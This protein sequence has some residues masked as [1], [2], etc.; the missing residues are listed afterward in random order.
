M[1]KITFSSK[2][3]YPSILKEYFITLALKSRYQRNIIFRDLDN[4]AFCIKDYHINIYTLNRIFKTIFLS[5]PRYEFKVSEI[6]TIIQRN[7]YQSFLVKLKIPYKGTFWVVPIT[8]Y[9]GEKSFPRG[10]EV[11]IYF[12]K[13]RMKR[14]I[15]MYRNEE[16][17]VDLFYRIINNIGVSNDLLY[18]IYSIKDTIKSKY[19]FKKSL[20]NMITSKKEILDSVKINNRIKF[21]KYTVSY[22]DKWDKYSLENNISLSYDN[23]IKYLELLC[24]YVCEV[25]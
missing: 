2:S 11:E 12:P 10:H 15:K 16:L 4:L 7:N 22:K 6:K 18:Q 17:A 1:K 20:I 5:D 13:L 14:N 24:S 21:L 23:I 8:V 9:S 19:L 25:K 3:F